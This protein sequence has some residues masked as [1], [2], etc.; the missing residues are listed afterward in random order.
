MVARS[1]PA[2][3]NEEWFR[4]LDKLEAETQHGHD[5]L[6]LANALSTLYPGESEQERLLNTMLLTVPRSSAL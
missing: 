5:F 3:R 2:T 1:W 6:R 4:K